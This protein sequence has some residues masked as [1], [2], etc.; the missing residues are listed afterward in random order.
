MRKLFVLK[1]NESAPLRIASSLAKKG[2]EVAISLMLDATYLASKNGEHS[3]AMRECVSSGV[4]VYIFKKDAER[5]GL[6]ERLVNSANMV[7]SV[8]LVDLFFS[9]ESSVINL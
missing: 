3:E 4:E 2:Q 9:K 6:G 8:G 7:D 1:K 5:R